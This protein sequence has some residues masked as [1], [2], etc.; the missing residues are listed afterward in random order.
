MPG[1]LLDEC[2]T[3]RPQIGNAY[4][5]YFSVEM[6]SLFR[7][8]HFAEENIELASLA[9][10]AWL[11]EHEYVNNKLYGSYLNLLLTTF[12]DFE[13]DLR[14]EIE[15]EV[16]GQKQVTSIFTKS[17]PESSSWGDMVEGE[18]AFWEARLRH[19]I[20]TSFRAILSFRMP[21]SR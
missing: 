7:L 8:H 21:H 3:T 1:G 19:H 10:Q 17:K 6:S 16:L 4:Q 20:T 15:N 13:T 2:P 5:F 12:E 11:A 14:S 9:C 18:E